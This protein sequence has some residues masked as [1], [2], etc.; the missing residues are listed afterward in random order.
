[1]K[2]KRIMCISITLILCIANGFVYSPDAYASTYE[3][4]LNKF[5]QDYKVLLEQVHKVYPNFVF[6]A[7]YVGI[8]FE[9]AVSGEDVFPKKLVESSWAKSFRSCG[10]NAYDFESGT[11]A[12]SAGSWVGASRETIA[13]YMDP[14]NFLNVN[15][16]YQFM[17]QSY[18][19]SA[20]TK[21]G[22]QSIV[23]GTFLANNYTEDGKT[24]SYVDIIMEAA[25]E[26]DVSPYFIA[27]TIILEQ[28]SKGTSSLISGTYTYND[29]TD[30]SGYYNFF[31]LGSTG[32]TNDAVIRNGLNYAKKQGWSTRKAAIVG[33]AKY[34]AKNYIAV[35]QDT[36]YYMD[37][38]V[39]QGNNFTHQYAQ[40]V[41]DALVKGGKL[42]SNYANDTS[43][44]EVFKI[45]V[46]NNMPDESLSK[47]TSSS[48]LNNYY[49]LNLS[50]SNLNPEF[51]M[52]T[53]EYTLSISGNTTIKYTLPNGASYTSVGSY[54][55]QKGLNVVGLEVKSQT[56]YTRD[57]RITITA[58]KACTLSVANSN[59]SQN[60][61]SS[62]SVTST[63]ETSS[64]TSSTS[65][66]TSSTSSTSS[67]TSSSQSTVSTV[68]MRGDPNCDGKI[69]VSDLAAIKFHLLGKKSLTGNKFTAA[70]VNKDGKL[71][72]SDLAAVKFHLLGKKTITQ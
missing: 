66:K 56:G 25:K 63:S 41:Y 72:V 59:T 57:Y 68:I 40:S 19:S 7:D 54:A 17:C 44:A 64:A 12:N 29:N 24:Y 47:P 33:G 10:E 67:K 50:V 43:L 6:V 55:L 51:N 27:S 14:R 4:E 31:N 46:Y 61:D 48:K 23:K 53:F 18:N 21:E 28:G 26:S 35:K 49:F 9:D 36:Y 5:P 60:T 39:V 42:K 62:S 22:V 2:I 16:I 71:T 69:T 58:S 45:P 1:M 65:S 52:Y 3:T 20:H 8:D 38:N 32:S 37:F 30:L 15:D 70:D 11:W 34:I 13:Y